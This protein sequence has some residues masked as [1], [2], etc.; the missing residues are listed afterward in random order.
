MLSTVLEIY[1][2]WQTEIGNYGNKLV[3]S[4]F[5]PFYPSTPKNPNTINCWRYHHFTEVFQKPQSYEVWFLIYGV[6]QTKVFVILGHF[7]SFCPPSNLEN[8]N[9][10]K[11]KKKHREISSFYTSVPK[12]MVICYTLPGIW[13]QSLI[14]HQVWCRINDCVHLFWHFKRAWK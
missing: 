13:T 3:I 6:K 10:E 1:R 8:Q 5:L 7:L 4:Y 11:M 9:F 14:L 2:V 12:I